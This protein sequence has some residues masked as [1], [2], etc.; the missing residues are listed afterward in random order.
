LSAHCEEVARRLPKK[1]DYSIIMPIRNEESWVERAVEALLNLD[2]P[3]DRIEIIVLDG[4]STDSSASIVRCLAE[5]HPNVHLL[6]NPSRLSSSARNIGVRN[7]SGD[8]IVFIEG[9]CFVHRDFLKAASDYLQRTGAGC[10]GRPIT[11][12]CQEKGKVQAAISLARSS[13]LGH[14]LTSQV[15]RNGFEGYV[16]PTSVATIYRRSVFEKVGL[17]DERFDA[18]EDLE[19]NYRVKKAG[20]MCYF[21]SK[22]HA[23]Y[24]ARPT[25]RQLFLQLR[26]YGHGRL[27][28]VL[29]HPKAVS[30]NTMIPPM[31]VLCLLSLSFV[32]L[33]SWNLFLLLTVPIGVYLLLVSAFSARLTLLQRKASFLLVMVSFF[34]IHFSLGLGFL[35][36][37]LWEA[38]SRTSRI[39]RPA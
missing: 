8:V 25:F 10:L 37:C 22:M 33:F 23:D 31:F 30:P 21:G 9:H 13:P 3:Q 14:S 24:V 26:R 39:S 7:S 1:V 15:Y 17:F 38:M 29:K 6:S 12:C 27:K 32:W 19:L 28:F 4:R 35:Q 16:D 20:I 2:Y 5:K 18:C 11:L 34:V 36:G